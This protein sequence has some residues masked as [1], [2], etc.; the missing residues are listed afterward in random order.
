[1]GQLHE[2]V[3]LFINGDGLTLSKD[4]EIARS[5]PA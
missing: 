5:S 1:M 2:Y 3:Q 4:P